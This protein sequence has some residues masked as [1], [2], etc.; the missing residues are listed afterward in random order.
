MK[1]LR[2]EPLTVHDVHIV[3]INIYEVCSGEE[4]AFWMMT[5]VVK[6]EEGKT[7]NAC[8]VYFTEKPNLEVQYG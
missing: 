2:I 8:K 6:S 1:E 4:D 3:G 7:T 5:L